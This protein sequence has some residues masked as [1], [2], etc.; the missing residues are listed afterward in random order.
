[1]TDTR[2]TASANPNA[3]GHVSI[4]LLGTTIISFWAWDL[5]VVHTSQKPGIETQLVFDKGRMWLAT[6]ASVS[7]VM[8]AVSAAMS[9]YGA[10]DK[11]RRTPIKAA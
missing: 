10:V 7:D 8:V 6:T 4:K 2:H 11:E 1:M 5:M 3:P 9:A